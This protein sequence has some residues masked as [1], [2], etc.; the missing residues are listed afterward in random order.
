MLPLMP[1]IHGYTMV[2]SWKRKDMKRQR[3]WI[4][5]QLKEL[6]D[7]KLGLDC[8][9]LIARVARDSRSSTRFSNGKYRTLKRRNGHWLKWSGSSQLALGSC[10]SYVSGEN[11]NKFWICEESK[12]I[13]YWKNWYASIKP[14]VGVAI[15]CLRWAFQEGKWLQQAVG[16]LPLPIRSIT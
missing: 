7:Q 15:N 4:Y 10:Y 1:E 5:Q 6:N 13:V 11:S 8:L 16:P 2:Y 3:I 12:L 9:S 14:V